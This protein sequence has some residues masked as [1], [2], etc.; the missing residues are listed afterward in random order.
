MTKPA[1]RQY[2][3]PNPVAAYPGSATLT[4]AQAEIHRLKELIVD[5]SAENVKL[6][7]LTSGQGSA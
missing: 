1:M 2:S 6:R 5:R 3:G 7:R 4:D